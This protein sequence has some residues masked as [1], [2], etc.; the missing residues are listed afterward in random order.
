[1]AE[2]P[3]AA[4]PSGDLHGSPP[5]D[6]SPR[7]SVPRI[8][9]QV[10]ALILAVAAA[11]WILHELEGVLLLL[12]LSVFFAYLIAPLVSLLRR[13]IA[14]RGHPRSLPLPAAIAASY[15]LV[16]GTVALAV[17]LLLPVV[18]A[19]VQDLA[20]AAPQYLARS[21]GRVQA[22]QSYEQTHL[23]AAMRSS[24]NAA[25]DRAIASA[26]ASIQRGALPFLAAL[27]GFLPWLVLVPILALFLLKD[28]A[29]FRAGALRMVPRGRLRWRGDDFF[30]DVNRTLAA[31]VRAQLIACLIVG[32]VCTAGF[33]MIGVPYA[34]VLGIAAGLLEF[35]PLAGPLT[36]G[37][38]AVVF[39]GFHSAGQA[40]STLLFLLVLRILEDYVVY[41][42]LI[43]HGIHLHPLAVIL[44]ILS[45]AE[46]AGLAGIFLSIPVV[47][48][49]SVAVRHWREHRLV[50][51]ETERVVTAS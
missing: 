12:V 41:P 11:L 50:E 20:Q 31:Y 33:A 47:A 26:G 48:I 10:L 40:V 49:V 51:A 18:S 25:V 45:G 16:F 30:Q 28:A 15:V 46:L 13:P 43:R 35:I 8:T 17:W 32:A 34:V 5:S 1:M 9:L 39:A 29:L 3:A 2:L 37:F 14:V 22:W 6:A 21:H 24:L 7:P 38:V 44:A 4:P 27:L 19:Q 42:R 36:I 23:P